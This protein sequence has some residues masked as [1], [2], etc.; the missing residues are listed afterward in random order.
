MELPSG[1]TARD[2]GGWRK[3]AARRRLRGAGLAG[4]VVV[5]VLASGGPAGAAPGLLGRTALRS[6]RILAPRPGAMVSG[7]STR[8][9]VR[10]PGSTRSFRVLV[11]SR[12]LTGEFRVA[13]GGRRVATL[14]LS[15]IGFGRRTLYL[16]TVDRDGR[17]GYAQVSF[18]VARRVNG[19]LRAVV[20]RPTCASGAT[21][22]I[23][24]AK[25]RLAVRIWVN[26]RA[27]RVGG[28]GRRRSVSLDADNGLRPGVNLIRVRALDGAA[29]AYSQRDVRMVMPLSSPVAGAGPSRW[30]RVG[31]NVSFNAGASLSATPGAALSYRW[32]IVQAP[33]GSRAR[34]RDAT[35][36]VP[37]LR[38]DRPGRYVLQVTVSHGP[39][40]P[41]TA[42][43][44]R[45]GVLCAS[46]GSSSSTVTL[47]AAVNAPPLGVPVDTIATQNGKRGVLLGDGIVADGGAFY[48]VLDP[49]K[50]LQLVILNRATLA[51]ATAVATDQSFAND[52]AGAQAL[53][54]VVK[55][56]PAS[57]IVIIAKPDPAVTNIPSGTKASA[58]LGQALASI[59]VGPLP[60]VANS[61]Q[62]VSCPTPGGPCSSFSA[63]G[64]PGLPVGQGKV[65]A[66][67]SGV[68][69]AGV[70]GG[71][72]HG[73]FAK[74]LTNN[75]FVFVNRERVVFD[76]GDPNANPAVVKVGD[77]KYTSAKVSGAGFF[78]VTLDAGS[79]AFRQQA[80]FGIGTSP[81]SGVGN[82]SAMAQLLHGLAAQ[83]DSLVIVRSIGKVASVPNPAHNGQE[84]PWDLVADALQ[85]LGGSTIYFDQL[86]GRTSAQYA[87]VGPGGLA[88][89]YPD[90]E[91]QIASAE[92]SAPLPAGTTNPNNGRLTG[93]LARDPS[94][95]FYPDESVPLNPDGTPLP[96]AGTLP[97]LI[98]MPATAWPYRSSPGDQLVLKCVA[99]EARIPY[100]V[101][102]NYYDNSNI[103]WGTLKSNLDKSDYYQTLLKIGTDQ[104][105]NNCST[106]D[107]TDFTAVRGQLD[108]EW[109][110]VPTVQRLITNLEEPF[111]GPSASGSVIENAVAQIDESLPTTQ[112]VAVDPLETAEDILWILSA[113]PVEGL[114]NLAN[115]A[116]G[117]IALDLA[118]DV[119]SDG[120]LTDVTAAGA[121]LGAQL[122]A[123]Y[124]QAVASLN[125]ERDILLSD[126]GKLQTAALNAKNSPD[127]PSGPNKTADWAFDDQQSQ[128]DSVLTLAAQRLAYTSLFPVRYHLYR[129]TAGTG[130]LNP[131]DVTPYQCDY[132]QQVGRNYVLKTY[133]PFRGVPRFGGAAPTLSAEGTVEQWVYAG[134]DVGFERNQGTPQFPPE[135]LLQGMFVAP[136][137]NDDQAPLFNLLQ[138]PLEA[139]A[140]ATAN[141]VS[142]T[143]V[144]GSAGGFSGTAVSS[145][146]V[147]QSK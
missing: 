21:L 132:F 30:A 147:C 103:D 141:I 139:Y 107:P 29:G 40:R 44:G 89:G 25:P 82:L 71:D 23:G 26:G 77:N 34:L 113:V 46:N 47:Q 52:A 121:Q 115:A 10:L 13:P 60:D 124:Q 32:V 61:A 83:P 137:S 102:A 72:L 65:N 142:V 28:A 74:A 127:T 123:R 20:A 68:P 117:A 56:L 109:Q 146:Q 38:P 134:P 92:H 42:G 63:I 119:N 1:V 64:V 81:G 144:H 108:L 145:N 69:G 99:D 8:A 85:Q 33:R 6:L 15:G 39:V 14:R 104:N 4:L 18:V 93:L 126:W 128:A 5:C 86:N 106:I 140:N 90:P 122:Q 2:G 31:Q 129:L 12:V 105:G 54:N 45:A 7:T 3:C 67:L 53:F 138:F 131:N 9:V 125:S 16:R 143:H 76:T 87:Q 95:R 94:S 80:T 51:P 58:S 98:S 73:Y 75:S 17:R 133:Y 91:T 43:L 114:S 112:P 130:S 41:P 35:S 78:V 110:Y 50:A 100:P 48:P 96:L 37:V 70:A 66:G 116:A 36:R 101:E 79:L 59:G 11:G 135:D 62:K 49:S 19:L 97:G 118:L 88:A 55:G 120:Q 111:Y 136:S 22:T 84:G 24:L 27:T 57:D